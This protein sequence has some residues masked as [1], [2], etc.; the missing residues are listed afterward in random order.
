MKINNQNIVLIGFMGCGKTT[1]GENLAFKLN[2]NFVDS[3]REIQRQSGITI[4]E[5]FDL[6]DED[7]FRQLENTTI[8]TICKS[9]KQVIATGGGIIKNKNNIDILR[10][11]GIIL[12]LKASPEHIYNNIKDDTSRPLLQCE[13]KLEKIKSLLNQ[14]ENLY[15]MYC[16]IAIEVSYYSVDDIT[17]KILTCIC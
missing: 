15:K 17:N 3:D 10:E 5:I 9:K 16:D 6:Y 12:Y 13:N 1:V 8:K 4:N 14:R 2:Y 7:Y 11:E